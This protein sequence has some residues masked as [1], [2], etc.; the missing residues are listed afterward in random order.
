MEKQKK[1]KTLCLRQGIDHNI[2]HISS[3][4]RNCMSL[5]AAARDRNLFRG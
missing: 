1:N 3:D 5:S 2:L 4:F